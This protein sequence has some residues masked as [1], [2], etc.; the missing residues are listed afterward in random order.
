[1]CYF[2]KHRL[3]RA[4]DARPDA[5]RFEIKIRSFELDPG[6]PREPEPIETAYIRGHGGDVSGALQAE[7]RAQTL[8][9][10]EG[11]PFDVDR[12]NANTFDLHRVMHLAEGS[13]K[14]LGFFSQVQDRFF[15]G[16]INPYDADTLVEVASRSGSPAP[17]CGRSWPVTS[18]PTRS[19]RTSQKAC[20]WEHRECRSPFSVGASQ[21]PARC[22]SRPTVRRSTRP[23]TL[24]QP[25][26]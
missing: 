22:R 3:Q 21:R 23:S 13:G 25:R 4:I 12:M 18:T 8:A 6:F 11:L 2:G 16:E 19:A 14:G 20:R 1:M 10:R 24:S 5:E 17:A 15:A 7:T 26:V 9:R